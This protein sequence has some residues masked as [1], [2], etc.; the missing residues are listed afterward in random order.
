[1]AEYETV[2]PCP[3]CGTDLQDFPI[4]M[5]VT[6]VH[7]DEYLIAKLERKHIIGSDADYA[8]H[9][10]QCGAVGERGHTREEAIRYWNRR[11]NSSDPM[12]SE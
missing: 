3:F 4:I 6:P 7:S 2:K 9:C 12:K 10:I 8:V 1:M 11:A 5:I